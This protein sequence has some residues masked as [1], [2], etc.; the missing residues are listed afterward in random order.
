[1]TFRIICEVKNN[2]VT[3]TLPA[4]FSHDGT[5]TVAGTSLFRGYYPAWVSRRAP[6]VTQDVGFFDP[7]GA[8]HIEGR[9][10]SLIISGGEKVDPLQVESA[11]RATGEFDDVAVLG[12]PDPE[13]GAAVVACY[14]MREASPDWDKVQRR[15]RRELAAYRRPKRYVGVVDWPRNAQGKLNRA[16]LFR[17][18]QERITRGGFISG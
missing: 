12:M 18:A 10:D 4:D 16:T 11:L 8:L 7:C 5:V 2:Q 13:W 6:W 1:M 14:P 15:L 17:L 9:R 3:L